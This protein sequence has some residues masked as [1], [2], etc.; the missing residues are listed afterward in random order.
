[1]NKVS[2]K[3]TRFG[4]FVT[5]EELAELSKGFVL[6]NTSNSTTCALRNFKAWEKARKCRSLG[7]RVP[8]NLLQTSDKAI[9]DRWLSRYV[10]ETRNK[11]GAYYPPATL[12]QL[13]IG[14]LRYMRMEN[15]SCPN[16]LDKRDL[17]FKQLHGTL[18]SHF[19]KL[20]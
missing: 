8:P 1:M 13:L 3:T 9:L 16:F 11:N 5:D 17:A 18:N 4:N 15:S 14:I 12:Y 20:H 10:V 2:K 19:R 7:E 6:K